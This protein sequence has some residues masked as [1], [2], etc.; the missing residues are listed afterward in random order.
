[1]R[2]K[3]PLIAIMLVL[4]LASVLWLA[5]FG[6][7]HLMEDGGGGPSRS[8]T[9]GP[10]DRDSGAAGSQEALPSKSGLRRET[11]ASPEPGVK[12]LD[13]VKRTMREKRE[14]EVVSFDARATARLEK[15]QSLMT[16][17]YLDEDGRR[18]FAVMTPEEL[19]G[20]PDGTAAPTQVKVSC[21]VF[22]LDPVQMRQIGLDTLTT[23]R[24]DNEQN[25]E[26][27]G[28]DD[29]QSTLASLPP[30]SF[31]SRPTMLLFSGQHGSIEI[32]RG[33]AADSLGINAVPTADGGF[34]IDTGWRHLIG[35]E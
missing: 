1:M 34:D 29:V 16:G 27:W 15:G 17:G 11:A 10:A 25:A 4:I 12:E 21:T 18:V 5:G 23:D 33:G 13:G 2:M 31:K 22:A 7:D 14:D 9:S 35:S 6:P 28:V 24:R 30:E 26:M 8:N 3:K 19:P 32:S 20:T